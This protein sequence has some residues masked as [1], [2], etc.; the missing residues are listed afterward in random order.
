MI[1]M[2]SNDNNDTKFFLI[3]TARIPAISSSNQITPFLVKKE[4]WCNTERLA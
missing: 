3:G 2:I 4:A 1:I